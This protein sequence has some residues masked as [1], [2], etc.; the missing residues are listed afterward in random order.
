[1]ATSKQIVPLDEV[2]VGNQTAEKGAVRV[3]GPLLFCC[4]NLRDFGSRIAGRES[5]E[6]TCPFSL[7]PQNLVPGETAGKGVR[8]AATRRPALGQRNGAG[9]TKEK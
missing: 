5:N 1:M 4:L 8:G 7:P 9:A 6:T 2:S 3:Q